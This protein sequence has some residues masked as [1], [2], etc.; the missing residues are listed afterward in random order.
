MFSCQ[1]L[2]RGQF[3]NYNSVKLSAGCLLSV[4]KRY[5][6]LKMRLAG[7]IQLQPG[8][9]V[10]AGRSLQKTNYWSHIVP[11]KPVNLP[12]D[13]L[14]TTVQDS[15]AERMATSVGN[16]ADSTGWWIYS[17]QLADDGWPVTQQPYLIV[18]TAAN[19]TQMHA[20][21]QL[22]FIKT[23]QQMCYQDIPQCSRH[24]TEH[25]GGSNVGPVQ[26]YPVLLLHSRAKLTVSIATS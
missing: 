3:I 4:V 19:V 24:T 8:S 18:T 26:I 15:K 6:Q 9:N 25:D 21:R 5:G 16:V 7:V 2:Q 23:I 14:T 20:S 11:L 22:T 12:G 13:T 10:L 1:G 17:V